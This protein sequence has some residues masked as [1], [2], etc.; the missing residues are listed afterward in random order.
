MEIGGA[1]LL[2]YSNFLFVLQK[3]GENSAQVFIHLILQN[4]KKE[5]IVKLNN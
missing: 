3:W 5:E 1:T 2:L 4:N